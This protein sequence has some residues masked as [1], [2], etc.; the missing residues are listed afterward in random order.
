MFR[1]VGPLLVAAVVL[2]WLSEDEIMAAVKTAK[3]QR[4]KWIDENMLAA[5]QAVEKELTV[6]AA[7]IRFKVARKTLED[8]VKGRVKHGTAPGPK[9]VLTAEE[10]DV[11][12]AYLVYMAERGFPL[13]RTMTKAF[14]WAI[15]KR[16]GKGDHF[17][18]ESGPGE[19]WWV[20]FR[21]RHPKLTLRKADKLERSRAE[22]LNPEVIKEYFDLL[23]ATLDRNGLTNSSRQLY[24][25]DETFLPLDYTREKAVTVKNSKYVY[26]QSQGTTDHITVLCTA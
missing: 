3:H 23:K 5:M 25:C 6:A 20:N 10:E 12:V 22:A 11:L 19:H 24:N 9:T 8:R 1:L 2:I 4:K 17:N 16:S 18:P 14:A 21:K 26:A 15:A 13:T 7:A